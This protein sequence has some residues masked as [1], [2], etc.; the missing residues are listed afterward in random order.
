M[1][2]RLSTLIPSMF[3]RRVLLLS[4]AVGLAF[5]PLLLATGR[6]ALVKHEELFKEAEQRLMRR[7]WTATTRGK[8]LDRKGR[9]LTVDRP[10]YGLAIQYDV[11]S[12]K[13]VQSAARRAAIRSHRH[14]WPDL[15][16][17]RQA[18]LVEMYRAQF[19]AHM[20]R[21]WTELA[22]TLNV[23]EA[24]LN[25]RRDAAVE[26]IARAATR[27]LNRKRVMELN[28]AAERG[29]ELTP[30]LMEE[31]EK[32]IARPIAEQTAP[33]MI[34]PK[35]SDEA[36]LRLQVAMG[37]EIELAVEGEDVPRVKVPRFPGMRISD[38]GD[39]E[40][41]Y[42][43]VNVEIDRR[44]LPT[45]VRH[46]DVL[47]VRVEGVAAHILGRMRSRPYEQDLKKR[48]ER[49]KGDAVFAARVLTDAGVDRGELRDVDP[50]GDVGIEASQELELRGL[51]GVRSRRMDTGEE[52]EMPHVPGRDVMLT[53][54]VNLQ[55]R[56]QAAMQPQ[57]GL[58]VA[59]PWHRGPTTPLNPTVPDGTA[60]NGAAVVIDIESGEILA[61]VSTPS[62]SRAQLAEDA[63][64]IFEDE[65]NTPYLDRAIAKSYAAGSIVKPLILAGAA[66][67]GVYQPGM[68]IA[69]TGHLLPKQPNMYRCWIYKQTEGVLN[70]TMQLERNLSGKDALEVSCNIFFFTLGQKLGVSGVVETYK[71]FGVGER[72][73]LGVGLEFSGAMGGG[74]GDGSGL[75]MGDAVQMGIGQ[76]PISWT[77]LHAANAYATLARGG[78]AVQPMLVKGVGG[79]AATEK[80]QPRDLELPTWALAEAYLGLEASVS[81]KRGTGNGI[82]VEPAPGP[83][84]SFF[85]APNVVVWGKT[86]TAT[87]P[88]LKVKEAVNEV[89]GE[90]GNEVGG[91]RGET[92]RVVRS[93]DHSWFVVLAGPKVGGAGSGVKMKYAIAVVMDYAGSGGKVSGPICN[94]IIHALIAEGYL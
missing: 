46:E 60:L 44:S 82:Q 21:S 20:A 8:I 61:M 9:V 28:A 93:G 90:D 32:R 84:E 37:D 89:D 91:R 38:T 25:E 50:V 19:A 33:V 16:V 13:W 26:R 35:I 58:A 68:T 66:K 29:D 87:A 36:G 94:Q 70:H 67:R 27:Q 24:T 53:I 59:Q 69:C 49:I 73:D 40:Y 76:G 34:L 54:D 7:Q 83:K 22:Q 78:V 31:I 45:P 77:P 57:V 56:V 86:G 17:Q 30:R 81:G 48:E 63:E 4:A 62:F 2:S 74:K 42:D 43:V 23:S 12:G 79:S 72:F 51:R 3:H 14:D 11:L 75:V 80:K 39:R 71:M 1:D 6:L 65:V 85:N 55:A 18:E 92:A 15:P 52:V 10:A 64:Q 41:P 5:A 88:D 47:K